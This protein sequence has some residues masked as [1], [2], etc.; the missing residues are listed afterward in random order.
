MPNFRY[1]AGIEVAETTTPG[2]PGWARS[3]QPTEWP[4]KL[5]IRLNSVQLS[6]SLTKLGNFVCVDLTS[7]A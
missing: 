4:D 5:D 6:W 2:G 7:L 3:G 1:H